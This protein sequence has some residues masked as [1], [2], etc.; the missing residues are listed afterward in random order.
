ME[1]KPRTET[2]DWRSGR[3]SEFS[4]PV[5][6]AALGSVTMPPGAQYHSSKA[7]NMDNARQ[8]RCA[9]QVEQLPLPRTGLNIPNSDVEGFG[10]LS[11]DLRRDNPG[12]LKASR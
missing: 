1:L 11:R 12:V 6:K 9:K 7:K 4:G 8:Q 3:Y 2:F 5:A 10:I